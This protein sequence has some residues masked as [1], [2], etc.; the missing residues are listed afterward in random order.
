MEWYISPRSYLSAAAFYKSIKNFVTGTIQAATFTDPNSGVTVPFT[1]NGSANG[2]S[3]KI[4]GAEGQ[5]DG[6]IPRSYNLELLYEKYGWSNQ[7][8][9]R[10]KSRFTHDLSSPYIPGLPIVSDEYKDLSAT[11]SYEFGPH[12]T[13]NIE[14]SNLLNN[15]DFRFSTYRNVPA[16]YEAWGR[17]YFVG[18]RARL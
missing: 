2:G 5:L 14:G 15:A 6:V 1:L 9:Y 13:A 11:V 8:S 10:Y 18:V 7:I 17:A 3:A 16:Y 12:I 4:H